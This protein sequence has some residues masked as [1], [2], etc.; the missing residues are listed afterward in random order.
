[1]KTVMRCRGLMACMWTT[2]LVTK[3]I[4]FSHQIEAKVKPLSQ[5][6]IHRSYTY[7]TLF[8]VITAS[9]CIGNGTHYIIH[10][11]PMQHKM[12]KTIEDKIRADLYL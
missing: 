5:Y 11:I 9:D 12:Q 4:R 3:R 10:D 7:R 8:M 6:L 2:S 1:M